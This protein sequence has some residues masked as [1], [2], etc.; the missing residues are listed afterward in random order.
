MEQK[1]KKKSKKI[2]KFLV[3]YY[4]TLLFLAVFGGFFLVN[5]IKSDLEKYTKT[6]YSVPYYVDVCFAGA[7]KIDKLPN[8]V[9]KLGEYLAKGKSVIVYSDKKNFYATYNGSVYIAR[10][11][12]VCRALFENATKS[13]SKNIE[14]IIY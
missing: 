13:V 6:V 5:T 3:I 11:P 12:A 1:K 10:N 8:G 4:I 7:K 2:L 14:K 9:K